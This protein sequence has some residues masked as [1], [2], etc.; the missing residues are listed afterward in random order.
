VSS[1]IAVGGGHDIRLCAILIYKSAMRWHQGDLLYTSGRP[2]AVL[3]V[4]LPSFN[5]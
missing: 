4:V 3:A 2:G 1:D 5:G